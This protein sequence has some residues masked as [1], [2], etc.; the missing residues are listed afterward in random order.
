MPNTY[1][2]IYVHI[3]FTVKGRE[4]F[5]NE[6]KREE[7]QMYITGIV[8]NKKQTFKEE[9]IEFLQKFEIDYDDKYLFEFY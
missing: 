4:T 1:S 9:Y 3:I 2:Q 5:I 6:S 7:I 8:T